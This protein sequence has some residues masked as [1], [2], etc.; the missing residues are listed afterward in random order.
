MPGASLSLASCPRQA[1]SSFREVHAPPLTR[2][3]SDGTPL[4][5]SVSPPLPLRVRSPGDLDMNSVLQSRQER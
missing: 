5:A 2:G 4:L 3:V 1:L